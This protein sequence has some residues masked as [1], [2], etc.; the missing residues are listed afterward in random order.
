[1]S[2][3]L[4]FALGAA[5][6]LAGEIFKLWAYKGKLTNKKFHQLGSSL[7]F[8]GVLVAM[9]MASG[10]V[11]WVVNSGVPATKLQV[12]LTGIGARGI[13]RGVAEAGA[14]QGVSLGEEDE[15]LGL[16]DLLS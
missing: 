1:M 6:S 14:A 15:R 2:D 12:V 9:V 16:K 11:A 7:L 10:F 4:V 5:G 13:L 8:W 3:G